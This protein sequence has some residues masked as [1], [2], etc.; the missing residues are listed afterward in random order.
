MVQG[1]LGPVL[2]AAVL[3]RP[4]AHSLSPLLHTAGYRALGLR[5][6][7]YGAHD[8][9]ADELAPWVADR[10][11]GWRGLSLTMP[12]KE[13]ALAVAATVSETARLT[14][15]VN[16]LVRREDLGWDAHNTDV[17][18]LVA[19]LAHVDHGGAAT[20]LG[21]GATARSAAVA[22]SELGV[23]RVRV[24]ARNVVTATEVVALLDSLDVHAVPVPLGEWAA[25]PGGVVVST[26]PPPAAEAAAVHLPPDGDLAGTT[27]LDV[28]YADWPTPLARAAEAAGAD[29]VSG[30]EML[31]HQAA[32]QFELFTGQ[33]APVEVMLAAGREALGR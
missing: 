25:G 19:A 27:L 17:H 13:A 4:V 21:S 10:D 9:G 8:L 16:T 7:T 23:S 30:L 31:V 5:D 2:N 33:A 15:A 3:G 11:E 28:V 1:P 22:L 18:G 24:A 20:L 6:W 14:G 29:V 32:R 26:L 12:L